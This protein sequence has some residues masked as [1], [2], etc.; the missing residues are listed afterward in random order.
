M[1]ENMD[2]KCSNCEKKSTSS[3]GGNKNSSENC[4]HKIEAKPKQNVHLQ[5]GNTI[6][7]NHETTVKLPVVKPKV[8]K[9][10]V[11]PSNGTRK[12]V[13]KKPKGKKRK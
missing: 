3:C 10:K 1:R 5:E 2:Q 11:K 13:I 4:T 6:K 12:A 9:P 8:E 7:K